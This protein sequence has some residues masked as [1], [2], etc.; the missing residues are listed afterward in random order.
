MTARTHTAS[1]DRISA[2]T[3]LQYVKE[4]R[5]VGE[6]ANF[7]VRDTT[8]GLPRG[9]GHAV[10]VYPGFLAADTTTFLLRRRLAQA[11]L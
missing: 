9:D 6:F 10:I 1:A 3:L 2:P 8:K 5:A 7:L 4:V 11:R